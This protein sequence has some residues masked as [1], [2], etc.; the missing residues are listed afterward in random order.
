MS[1][2]LRPTRMTSRRTLSLLAIALVVAA[3]LGCALAWRRTIAERWL[4]GELAA[5]G[6]APASLS[7]ARLDWRGIGV[8]DLI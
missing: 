5:R 6:F 7:V 8:R 2:Y 1:S 3:L 4:I